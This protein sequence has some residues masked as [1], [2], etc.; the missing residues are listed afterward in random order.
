MASRVDKFDR[1]DFGARP[2]QFDLRLDWP[3]ATSQIHHVGQTIMRD[4]GT[5]KPH[6]GLDIYAPAGAVVFSAADGIVLR[7]GRGDQEGSTPAQRKA[8]LWIDVDCSN[9]LI[10]RYLHLGDTFVDKSMNI[11]RGSP[12][13]VV[14]QPYKS[15]LGLSG[16]HLHFE[17]RRGD[18]G[19]VGRDYGPAI[20]PLRFLPPLVA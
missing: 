9:G 5:G 15:G 16:P 11:K 10:C 6:L 14:A 1:F 17:L 19:T 18:A 3:I 7:V 12:I 2:G 8:G 4:R 20:N 13:A